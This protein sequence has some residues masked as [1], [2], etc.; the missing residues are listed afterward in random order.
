[1][2]P[3]IHIAGHGIPSYLLLLACALVLS[4]L[5]ATLLAPRLGIA[6]SKGVLLAVGSISLG[7]LGAK[8]QSVLLESGIGTWLAHPSLAKGFAEQG[9]LILGG[10]G[11]VGLARIMHLRV[12]DVLDLA[13]PTAAAGLSVGRIGCL[14]AGCCFGKPTLFPIA[15]VYLDF[16]A[17]ARP[18][19]VPLH[20][21]PI[22]SSI[23]CALVFAYLV[24]YRLPRRSFAGQAFLDLVLL[25][26]LFRFGIELLRADP[27]GPD[28][29]G[30]ST[31]QIIC[32]AAAAAVAV[33]YYRRRQ[34]L[35]R[36]D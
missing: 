7:L 14:L 25:Y 21:T 27:R 15:L 6:R 34:H 26:C 22:Y 5:V 13:A 1:M 11:L 19:G 8:A 9:G 29:L 18:I 28:L 33:P 12:G 10:L 24:A 36:S 31:P 23:A 32:L 17:P 20:A 35:S 30:L 4:T 2:H 16:S 3:T